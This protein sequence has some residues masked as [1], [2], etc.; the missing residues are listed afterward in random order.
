MRG[1][2]RRV[3]IVYRRGQRRKRGALLSVRQLRDTAFTLAAGT[4]GAA[5]FHAFNLPAAWLSGSML[6]VALLALAR[7]PLFLPELIRQLVW[8]MLGISIGSGFNP[9]IFDRILSWPLS[10]AGLCITILAGIA[11]SAAFLRVLGKWSRATAIFAS[12]PGAM[13]YVVA[14]SL[15][16]SADTR[17]VVMAQMLRLVALLAILPSVIS[18]SMPP[19]HLPAPNISGA[20]GLLGE[21]ALGGAIGLLLDWRKVPA[22]MLFGGMIGAAVLHLTSGVPGQI[23]PMVLIPCQVVFGCFIGLRFYGTD[24]NFLGRALAPSLG[25]F[26][27]AVFVSE[28]GGAHRGHGA[29]SAGRPGGGGVRAGRHRGDDPARLCAGPRPCLRRHASTRA[30]SGPVAARTAD[31]QGLFEGGDLE[32]VHSLSAGG[33][34]DTFAKMQPSNEPISFAL[35]S[36]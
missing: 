4:A 31:R 36:Q 22:G 8:I 35:F 5:I 1:A 32:H 11:A 28:S 23:P 21:V 24:L 9:E 16:S 25:A 18:F 14:L 12:V 34:K 10:I 27:I 15:R 19:P 26:L 33:G 17:L 7:A 13:S 3:Y 2:R 30:V 6:L 20:A 29:A